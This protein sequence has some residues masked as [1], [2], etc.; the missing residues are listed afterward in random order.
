MRVR[1]VQLENFRN[2]PQ[3][4][5]ACDARRVVLLGENG[6][7][8][9]NLL[10]AIYLG[11]TGSSFR[12]AR[13]REMIRWGQSGY[14]VR[15]E[16]E[17][18]D[19]PAE[20]TIAT[21]AHA[22]GGG[23][24]RRQ[25]QVNATAVAARELRGFFSAVVFTPDT[26]FLIKGGPQER[27]QFLDELLSQASSYYR[28]H[29]QRYQRVLAQRNHILQQAAAAGT[30]RARSQL[31]ETFTE[32][33]LESAAR[34][35]ERRLW[36]VSHLAKAAAQAYQQIAGSAEPFTLAYESEAVPPAT[37]MAEVE[38]SQD[39]VTLRHWL[40]RRLEAVA[41][42]EWRR[43]MTL[44]GPQRDDLRV[45]SGRV[46]LR[47]FGSQGQQRSAVLALKLAEV[48][49]LEQQTGRWPVFLLD[50]VLS[51]LDPD[52]RQRFLR[53]I[54]SPTQVWI[55]TAEPELLRTL[56]ADDPK[57]GLDDLVLHV[58]DGRMEFPRME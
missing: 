45:M 11:L 10:E 34:L 19:G 38:N 9:T 49:F 41:D 3:L 32:V 37:P 43:G 30:G 40:E 31:L 56:Q 55:T 25:V 42:L 44:V 58:T 22:D 53:T 5:V 20:V 29:L 39:W 1:E 2:Y 36:A 13:D 6:Q 26:L 35:W 27:R 21:Q 52:R 24:S 18:E 47:T 50:D 8:K 48:C 23:A 57:R 51:E 33:F 17:R 4:H 15:L 16:V 54:P 14:R 7:G 12:T 46:D 28:H